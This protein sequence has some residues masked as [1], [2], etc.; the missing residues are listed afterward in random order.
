MK[1]LYSYKTG[2]QEFFLPNTKENQKALL[3]FEDDGDWFLYYADSAVCQSFI[4]RI[5]NRTYKN[6]NLLFNLDNLETIK[7][8]EQ[9]DRYHNW[10]QANYNYNGIHKGFEV[11]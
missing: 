11:D 2:E 10:I 5:V 3:W 8:D 9:F 1:I 7:D 6:T 4:N